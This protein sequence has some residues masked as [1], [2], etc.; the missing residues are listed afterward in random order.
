MRYN[1]TLAGTLAK[2]ELN[3]SVFARTPKLFGSV[4]PLNITRA[5]F[6]TQG[7]NFDNPDRITTL[8]EDGSVKS[9]VWYGPTYGWWSD[10]GG[11]IDH[12]TPGEGYYLY[13]ISSSYK[14]SFTALGGAI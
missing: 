14:V 1:V 3:L 5:L 9:S 13:P 10:T 11:G 4:Y 8:L 6:P 12:L 2:S 7:E